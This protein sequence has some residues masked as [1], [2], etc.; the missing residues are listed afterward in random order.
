MIKSIIDHIA[1]WSFAIFA[2]SHG[3]VAA[4]ILFINEHRVKPNSSTSF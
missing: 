2:S 3:T 4:I 1:S